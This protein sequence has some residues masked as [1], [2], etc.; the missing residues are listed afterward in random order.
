MSSDLRLLKQQRLQKTAEFARVYELKVRY[1]DAQL[2]VFAAPNDLPH[3]RFGVSVSKKHGNAVR[4]GRLKRLLRE[5]FRLSQADL[6]AG[7]DLVLIPQQGANITVHELRRS[8]VRGAGIVS[9]KLAKRAAP[10]EG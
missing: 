8:L 7:V 1:G 9:R 10:Q 5:A 4:R 6:P 2:L 3:A